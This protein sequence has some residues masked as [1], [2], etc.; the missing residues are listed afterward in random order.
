M[1]WELMSQSFCGFLKPTK[2]RWFGW[3]LRLCNGHMRM[4]AIV[5]YLTTANPAGLV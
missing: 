2:I 3:W 5:R 4:I 1:H